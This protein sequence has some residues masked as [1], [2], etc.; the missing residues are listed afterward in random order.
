MTYVPANP[1]VYNA[2][3]AGFIAGVQNQQ[4]T[5][6]S[7]DLVEPSDFAT[8]TAAAFTFAAAVD[9]LIVALEVHEVLPGPI[10]LLA[11]GSA[12]IVPNTAAKANAAESTPRM[13][14]QLAMLAW[15]GRTIPTNADGTPLAASGYA[16][17]ANFLVS[18][19]IDWAT[20]ASAS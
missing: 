13:V 18:A 17:Q 4:L 16:A 2:A 12:T 6:N 5:E 7:G 15:S 9:T 1:V 19:L 20:S 11:T 8:V 14:Q 10:T 3:A